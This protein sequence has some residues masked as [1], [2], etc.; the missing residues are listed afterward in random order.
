LIGKE[1]GEVNFSLKAVFCNFS[2]EQVANADLFQAIGPVIAPQSVINSFVS[3][4]FGQIF[5]V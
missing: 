2:Q 4:L 3:S 5:K 1:S